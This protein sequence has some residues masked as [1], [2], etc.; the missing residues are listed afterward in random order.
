MQHHTIPVSLLAECTSAL[1]EAYMAIF[2][3]S[4]SSACHLWA[5][6]WNSLVRRTL[7]QPEPCDEQKKGRHEKGVMMSSKCWSRQLCK[8]APWWYRRERGGLGSWIPLVPEEGHKLLEE[9]LDQGLW[10]DHEDLRV[11]HYVARDRGWDAWDVEIH[12]QVSL[13]HNSIYFK[14]DLKFV[15]KNYTTQYSGERILHTEN[16]LILIW[17]S[18][19]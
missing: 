7:H 15:K 6:L 17:P 8:G 2:H 1:W 14:L 11:R 12:I 19:S 9:R 10:H 3:P 18:F 16:A 4:E 13:C 5:D